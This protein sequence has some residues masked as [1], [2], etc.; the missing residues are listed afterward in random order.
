MLKIFGVHCGKREGDCLLGY[1]DVQYCIKTRTFQKTLLVQCS[2][3]R[4]SREKARCFMGRR[5]PTALSQPHFLSFFPHICA[6]VFRRGLL[7]LW[8][9]QLKVEHFHT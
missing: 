8:I 7:I 3:R 5:V 1:D 6:L 9:V 2:S 4:N